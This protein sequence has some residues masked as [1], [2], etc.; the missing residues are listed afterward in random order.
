MNKSLAVS[1][2]VHLLA[3]GVWLGAVVMAGMSAMVVFP[4]MEGLEP[5]LP[6]YAAYDGAHSAL[7]AGRVMFAVFFACD[8]VQLCA[9]FFVVMPFMAAAFGLG[10]SMRRPV[11]AFR[12]A[13][14]FVLAAMLAFHLV[15]LTP[16]MNTE[17]QA[18][19][20]AAAEGDTAMAATHKAAFDA[21]H[22]TARLVLTA[23]TAGLA[24]AFMAGVWSVATAGGA[25]KEAE[26]PT[27]SGHRREQGEAKLQEPLLLKR[28]L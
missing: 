18:Y 4:T 8:L 17:L 28:R 13:L 6:A 19:W 20:Q 24:L 5:A 16:A 15:A 3:L 7:A 12:A 21:R 26:K 14:V 10:L 2:G 11:N 22:P 25:V 27:R 1:E 9:A 23:M